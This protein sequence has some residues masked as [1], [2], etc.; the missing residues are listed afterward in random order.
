MAAAA[1]VI[2]RT[3]RFTRALRFRIAVSYVLFF[4]VLLAVLLVVFRKSVENTFDQQTRA[5]L[6]DDWDAVK[7]YLRLGTAN[8]NEC[9]LDAYDPDEAF[10][11]NRLRRIYMLADSE[12]HALQWSSNKARV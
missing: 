11:V 8:G 7:G 9:F 1:S 10:I 6:E 2:V 4:T 5:L 3:F 12:G